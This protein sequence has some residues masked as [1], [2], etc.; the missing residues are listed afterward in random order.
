MDWREPIAQGLPR[1][2]PDE[3]AS[4]RR[5]IQDELA[6]HLACAFAREMARTPDE[7]TA[8]RAV[9]ARFGDPRKLARRLW[10]DA[11]KETI[12]NQRILLACAFR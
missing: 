2:H 1:P 8:R 6:D 11:M 9:L 7:P 5:D 10:L 3:P 12:M 4:L